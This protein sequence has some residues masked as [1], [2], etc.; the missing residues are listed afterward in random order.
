MLPELLQ[1]EEWTEEMK[2]YIEQAR[3]GM[4]ESLEKSVVYLLDRRRSI[5]VDEFAD[6]FEEYRGSELIRP[7]GLR[8]LAAAPLPVA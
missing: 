4:D 7:G 6:K 3:K 1:E 8:K 5:S 2:E